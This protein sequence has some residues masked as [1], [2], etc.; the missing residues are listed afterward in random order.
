MGAQTLTL[1]IFALL[2]T[3]TASVAVHADQV[4][5][6]L[7]VNGCAIQTPQGLLPDRDCDGVPDFADN[8]K[9]TP[10]PDQADTDHNGIGDACDLLITRID[11]DPGTEVQQGS[12]FTVRVTLINNKAYTLTNTQT[13]IRNV[14][15][16]MDVSTYIDAMQPSE[17]R[18][19][20]FVLKAPGCAAPG[21]YELTFSTDHQEG[22]QDFTQTLY[23]QV[24]ITARPGACTANATTLDNTILNTITSQTT[25][26]GDNVIYPV[27]ITN[28]NGETKTYSLTLTGIS[29]IGTYR[30][31]PD[32]TLTVPAGKYQTVNLYISTEAFAPLGRNTLVLNLSSDGDSQTTP[33]MLH[34][35]QPVGTSR[36]Q[37]LTTALQLGLI[38]IILALIIGAGIIAYRK[39]DGDEPKGKRPRNGGK[40]EEPKGVED[41]KE[42]EEFQSYY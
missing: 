11:L 17:Q 9:Y 7:P 30:I 25:T 38:I 1:L 31:D 16:N 10:N 32:S 34:I 40:P 21:K 23:Q 27:T 18:T 19:V 14:G 20:D 36:G 12:F 24:I 39:M 37:I 4:Q 2:V 8:C 3:A 13:R 15:L 41:V 33:L 42:E 28:L 26:A 35:I 22:Q 5:N 6:G 29:D